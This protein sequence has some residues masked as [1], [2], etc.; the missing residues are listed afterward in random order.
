MGDRMRQLREQ[1]M[2][3]ML[4]GKFGMIQIAAHETHV[5]LDVGGIERGSDGS[6]YRSHSVSTLLKL[7]DFVA[8]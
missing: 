2:P 8:C 4:T 6:V 5:L 1:V 3:V 7:S